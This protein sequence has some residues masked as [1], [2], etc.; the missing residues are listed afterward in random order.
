MAHRPA[1]G[2]RARGIAVALGLYGVW[3]LATWLLEGRMRTLLRPEDLVAR[4]IYALVANVIIGTLGAIVCV[5]W[6]KER[7]LLEPRAAGFP[8][9]RRTA[10]SV[11]VGLLLGGVF[12]WFRAPEVGAVV[13]V[14]AYAQVLVVSVA[15]VAVCWVVIGGVAR[16]SVA[17]FGRGA[18][19][20]AGAL[21]ASLA[22]G[23]YHVAHSPPFNQPAMIAFLAALGLLTSVF[24]FASRDVY[25]T[26]AFHNWLG[27]LGVVSA[28]E[29]SDRLSTLST[30]SP[31][32]LIVAAIALGVLVVADA[33]VVRPRRLAPA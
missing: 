16:S 32:L 12:A 1:E 26:V 20:L 8:R 21:A 5:S 10:L 3:T 30:P 11:V 33:Y 29:R 19:W 2:S 9:P 14:N 23:V 17:R 4:T 13:L 24:F 27:T 7:R 18:G 15:E 28:L 25:G 31:A 22:F 6:L